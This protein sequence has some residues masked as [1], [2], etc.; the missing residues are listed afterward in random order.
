MITDNNYSQLR[1]SIQAGDLAQVELALAN[2]NPNLEIEN[3]KA[4]IDWD[5]CCCTYESKWEKWHE[6]LLAIAIKAGH[7]PIVQ[8]LYLAGADI[9]LKSGRF[10]EKKNRYKASITTNTPLALA[11]IYDK[12]EIAD[13]L[14]DRGASANYLIEG[15]SPLEGIDVSILHLS[16]EMNF[17]KNT[18]EKMLFN[19]ANPTIVAN[20]ID[21]PQNTCEALQRVDYSEFKSS[22]WWDTCL[23][24]SCLSCC[25]WPFFITSPYF[26]CPGDV[27]SR[28]KAQTTLELATVLERNDLIE[29]LTPTTRTSNSIANLRKVSTFKGE[30]RVALSSQNEPSTSNRSDMGLSQS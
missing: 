20:Y 15:I 23:A 28:D 3:G 19:R 17:S 6:T 10:V 7:L 14:L 2:V 22:D 30:G 13:F 21:R 26:C 11:V 8:A 12:E 27:E 4:N 18:I 1:S 25:I 5:I 29:I 16:I 9:E 24:L